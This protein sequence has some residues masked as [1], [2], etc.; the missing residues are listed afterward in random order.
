MLKDKR[1]YVDSGAAAYEDKYK[2]QGAQESEVQ[3]RQVGYE[4]RPGDGLNGP[5][6]GCFLAGHNP[7][8]SHNCLLILHHCF[9]C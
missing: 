5:H 9:A 2:E 3:S 6:M 7:L 8:K 4:A 1:E